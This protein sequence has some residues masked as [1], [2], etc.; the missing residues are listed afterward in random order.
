MHNYTK[1]YQYIWDRIQSGELP[2]GS[3]IPKETDL[4]A[5][6]GVSRPTVRRALSDL[7]NKGYLARIPGKGSFVT[8]P[9]LLQEY[10][11]FIESYNVEMKKK[12]LCPITKVLELS[13]T[14][15]DECVRNHLELPEETRVIR[16]RRLRFIR[17][18]DMLKPM[19]LTTVYFSY[20]LLPHVF[21][22]N[23][24]EK[25]FYGVLAENNITI[26]RVRRFLEVKMLYGKTA[27]L[28]ELPEG[29]P[30]HYISSTGYDEENHPVEYSESF[31]PADRNQFIVE[32]V[33]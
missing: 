25:P 7:V 10:T 11:T 31:Y 17:E 2:E 32:I 12:G 15:P 5:Q 30:C 20:E 21:Q 9:K 6:F 1:V 27:G 16:L 14:Y 4:S 19:I 24:E 26:S 23:F 29:S 13:L 8:R 3:R 28:F 18:N 33:K 22:Y